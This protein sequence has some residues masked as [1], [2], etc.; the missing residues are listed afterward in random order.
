MGARRCK[1][2]RRGETELGERDRKV[3]HRQ[4]RKEERGTIEMIA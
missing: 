4:G 1:E 3:E 2:V